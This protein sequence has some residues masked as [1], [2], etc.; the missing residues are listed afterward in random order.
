MFFEGRSYREIVGGG[1]LTFGRGFAVGIS[2]SVYLQRVLCREVGIHILQTDAGLCREICRAHGGACEESGANQQKI[3]ETERQAKQFK[4]MYDNPAINV[5]LTFME[6]FPIG[7][8]VTLVS[9]G[10]LRRKGRDPEN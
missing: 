8:E 2:D 3:E 6:I 9:A 7:L 4:Q 1:G 10:T 5:A